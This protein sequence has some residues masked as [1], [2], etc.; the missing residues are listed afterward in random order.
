MGTGEIAFDGVPRDFLA[1]AQDSDPAL[2]TPA[3]RL[4]RSPASRRCPTG[5]RDARRT[6]AERG[7]AG[8]GIPTPSTGPLAVSTD[9]P[10]RWVARRQGGRGRDPH[11]QAP[12]ASGQDPPAADVRDLWV[13]LD[14][15]SGPRDVLRGVDLCVE[16]GERVALMGRNGAGKSTLLRTLAGLEEAVRGR[17]KA[18][19][20]IALLGQSPSDYLVRERVERRAARRGRRR[21]AGRGGAGGAVDADPRDLSG[22]ERQRLALAIALAGRMEGGALAGLVGLDEPTRGMDRARKGELVALI[23]ELAD[24]AP[25]RSSPPT[26]SS[27]P[28]PSPSGSCCSATALRSPTG[29]PPRSS[30]AAGT[31]PPRSPASSTCPALDHRPSRAPR[32][33][34]T[35][36][37][38]MSW[39][40]ASFLILGAVLLAGFAWYERSRPTSQRRRPGR[41]P[42]RARDRRPDRLRRLPQRQA[43]DRHRA[44]SPATPSGAAPGFAV[45]ALAAL[46]SNFWFGQGPWTPWQMAGWGLCGMPGAALAAR[47][48]RAGPCHAGHLLRRAGRRLRRAAELLSDGDLWR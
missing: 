1:W 9:R 42:R 30:P 37:A 29:R 18:P 38:A 32:C 24:A 19:G 44:S 14:D 10:L 45:G 6:L 47:R 3:A 34:A 21:R 17:A 4:S 13:A 23:E 36:E 43:D 11:P 28:P 7:L 33:S 22:G 5:V 8:R 2:E 25:G 48:S 41:R 35:R 40:A 15:G 39:Q 12:L 20:G 27:S 26:T 46:V 16:R 31:S